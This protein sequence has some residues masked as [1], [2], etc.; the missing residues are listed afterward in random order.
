MTRQTLILFD[1]DGTLTDPKPG[2]TGS[3][4]YALE[5]LGETVPHA[6]DL[7][8]T[9][10]PPLRLNF[11]RLVGEERADEGVRLYRERFG[12]TGLFENKLI[13]GIPALL[14]ALKDQGHRLVVATSKPHVFATRIVSHFN[15]DRYFSFVYGSELDGTHVDKRDLLRHIRVQESL[16]SDRTVMVGDREHDVHGA[17]AIDIPAIGV[18]WGYGSDE[19][20]LNAGA[21]ALVDSPHEI[22]SH[23]RQLLG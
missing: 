11:V 15:L 7:E 5:R 9:I 12:D 2:I 8:W 13:E 1:L 19:E 16:H 18:R 3:I 20:L 21:Y 4:Q 22:L 17:K 10:G 6:D 14:Q 23:V